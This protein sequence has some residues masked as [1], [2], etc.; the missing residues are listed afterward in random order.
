MQAPAET[1]CTSD[2]SPILWQVQ[3]T[4]PKGRGAPRFRF[5][6][7]MAALWPDTCLGG[8]FTATIN[9]TLEQVQSCSYSTVCFAPLLPCCDD[10][11]VRKVCFEEMRWLECPTLSVAIGIMEVDITSGLLI[12]VDG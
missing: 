9:E 5:G 6:L 3:W 4:V 2:F 8:V 11:V 10:H 12:G 7:M 1:E